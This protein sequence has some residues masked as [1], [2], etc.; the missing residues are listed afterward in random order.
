MF[1]LVEIPTKL[2]VKLKCVRIGTHN[3]AD[4]REIF[5]LHPAEFNNTY[6]RIPATDGTISGTDDEAKESRGRFQQSHT[7]DEEQYQDATRSLE[8]R[9]AA[10][11]PSGFQTKSENFQS[12]R[13]SA[14]V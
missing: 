8:A 7:A 9:C 12:Q 14:V 13:A 10:A 6:T 5:A 11:F 4:V 2:C 3:F 1:M